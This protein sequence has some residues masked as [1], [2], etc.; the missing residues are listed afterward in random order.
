MIAAYGAFT[1]PMPDGKLPLCI[2]VEQIQ[3][4]N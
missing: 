1:M 2:A 4:I 3:A